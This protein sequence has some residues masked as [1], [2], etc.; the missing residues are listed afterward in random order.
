MSIYIPEEE[1]K[2]FETS[3]E[4]KIKPHQQKTLARVFLCHF[5]IFE[6]MI[7]FTRKINLDNNMILGTAYQCFYLSDG[8]VHSDRDG[9]IRVCGRSCRD[10]SIN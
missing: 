10:S 7:N 1:R 2:K 8:Q 6:I 4:F 5:L 9:F 3:D